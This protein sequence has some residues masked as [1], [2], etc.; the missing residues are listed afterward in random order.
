MWAELLLDQA[1][2]IEGV[3][4]DP[5]ELVKRVQALLTEVSE[6]AVK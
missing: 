5:A 2:L 3:V 6:A 1:L 4:Q